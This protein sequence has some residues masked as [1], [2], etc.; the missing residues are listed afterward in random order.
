MRCLIAKELSQ[1]AKDLILQYFDAFQNLYAIISM[2]RALRI[3]RQQNPALELTDED[4][5]DFLSGYLNSEEYEHKYYQILFDCEMYDQPPVHD[6]DPL[7]Q[8]LISEYLYAMDTESYDELKEAQKD[9]RFYI[10]DRE[11]LLLYADDS[12]FPCPSSYQH[13]ESFLQ[14]VLKI[15]DE[16]RILEILQTI[17]DFT[18][19][20]SID[21]DDIPVITEE[22]IRISGIVFARFPKKTYSQFLLLMDSM[23]AETRRHV[24]RGFTAAEL[25]LFPDE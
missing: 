17:H 2:K 14:Q 13:M 12:Y 1:S 22:I 7:Q 9:Y 23:L 4:F 8:F 20:S 11:E 15:Q 10:P 24:F 25:G 3:I 16:Q 18:Q 21:E 6:A 19:I 5:I